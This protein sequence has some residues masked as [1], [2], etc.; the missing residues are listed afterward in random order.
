L[1]LSRH[2][3]PP[4]EGR[5]RVLLI[6]DTHQ[7]QIERRLAGR[8]VVERRPIQS[9]EFVVLIKNAKFVVL[10]YLDYAHSAILISCLHLDVNVVLSDI[11]LFKEMLP[12]YPLTFG[13]GDISQL[14]CI[15]NRALTLSDNDLLKMRHCNQ[16]LINKYDQELIEGI[17]SF[18]H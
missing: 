16:E 6:N 4:V 2:T 15:L 7:L 10:P 14:L 8:V 13:K 9:N 5:L 12:S 17:H 11:D 1:Q 18:F 3:G